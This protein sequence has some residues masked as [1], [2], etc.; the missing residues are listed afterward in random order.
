MIRKN[1][2][3]Q[4]NIRPLLDSKVWQFIDEMNFYR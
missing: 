2:A 4:K 1:I 3:A